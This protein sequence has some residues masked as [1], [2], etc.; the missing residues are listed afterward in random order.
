[1]N[2]NNKHNS[3]PPHPTR[4]QENESNERIRQ[5]F[6]DGGINVHTSGFGIAHDL[7]DTGAMLTLGIQAG[8]VKEELTADE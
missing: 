4:T 7:G 8:N 3:L 5:I 6:R 2:P 1:M